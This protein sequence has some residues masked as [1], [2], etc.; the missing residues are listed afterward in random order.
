M[1]SDDFRYFRISP[2]FWSRAEQ[3]DWTDDMKMLALYLLTCPHRT[4]EGLYRLPKQYAQADLEWSP[5]RFGEPFAQLL[6]DGFCDYD[7]QAQVV[8][9]RGALKYQACANANVATAA[10]K[11]LHELP[12][13][14][15]AWEFRQLVEQFDEQLA[16]Q[17]PEQF[18]D[19]PSPTPTPPPSPSLTP[20]PSPAD[21]DAKA[22]P[23]PSKSNLPSH[24]EADDQFET[25]WTT[26]PRNANSGKPGGGAPRAEA[27]KRWHKL[28]AADRE[29]ALTG[30]ANYADYC[31]R[32]D[33]EFAAHAT[34]WLN[35]RRWEDW[36]QPAAQ[37]K[38]NGHALKGQQAHETY[39]ALAEHLRHWEAA[40]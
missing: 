28:S 6:E 21:G 31:A 27:L 3:K 39:T 20:A 24:T 40:Q 15:L 11:R 1:S 5:E 37:P 30:V 17:L 7:E 26:Y 32:A 29:A 4:T 2:R 23:P 34:T 38:L 18:G 9:I 36:Q 12:E 16:K 35:Q 25:F 8:L 33:A 10:V 13:T 19:T 14:R 22:S